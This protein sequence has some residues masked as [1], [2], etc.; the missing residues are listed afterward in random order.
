MRA[1][2]KGLLTN[3]EVCFECLLTTVF[4]GMVVYSVGTIV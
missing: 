4:L 3:G 2:I 1:I